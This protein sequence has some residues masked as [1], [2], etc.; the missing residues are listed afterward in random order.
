MLV[1][2]NAMA[3]LYSASC[4]CMKDLGQYDVYANSIISYFEAKCIQRI[5]KQTEHSGST[6]YKAINH[7]SQKL[8]EIVIS[9]KYFP[10][11]ALLYHTLHVAYQQIV[12]V[13]TET[14]SRT[15]GVCG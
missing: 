2:I 5:V 12:Q 3:V 4:R 8:P 11:T 6:R 1:Y 13:T 7:V 9:Y 10:L 14:M 15:S